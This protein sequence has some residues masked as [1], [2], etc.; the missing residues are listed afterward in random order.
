MSAQTVPR[1]PLWVTVVLLVLSAALI[2]VF[3]LLGNWQMRRL[4]WKQDLIA[5]VGARAFGDPAD[6]PAQF[7]PNLHAYLRVSVDGEFLDA[8]PILIK[9]VTEIGPGYWVMSPMQT[10]AGILWVNRGFVPPDRRDPAQWAA[11]LAPITG[12]LRPD[13]PGGTLMERNRPDAD[14]WVSR[15]TQA[16]SEAR[17]FRSTLPYFLDADHLTGTGDWPR[18]GLTVVRFSNSHLSYALTWYAMAVLFAAALVYV[19]RSG[20]KDTD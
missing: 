11:P 16:M 9:A 13:S 6:M 15:D 3:V 12:L 2:V 14:R 7:D 4:G 17:G 18:G 10:E 8:A 19:V 20:L 1:R 5:V